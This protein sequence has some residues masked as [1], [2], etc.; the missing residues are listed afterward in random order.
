MELGL[1]LLF[2]G[3]AY[4]TYELNQWRRD[5]TEAVLDNLWSLVLGLPL[6]IVFAGCVAG[7][8]VWLI[9]DAL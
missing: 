6:N 4:G 8:G 7:A 9:R 3:V 1:F 5:K 2:V